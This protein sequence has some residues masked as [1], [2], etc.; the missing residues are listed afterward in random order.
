MRAFIVRPFGT[1]EGVDFDTIQ[2]TDRSC[3]GQSTYFRRYD[4][5]NSGSRVRPVVVPFANKIQL[6][7]KMKVIRRA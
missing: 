1:K 4:S 6:T 3:V 7:N 2:K 5:R